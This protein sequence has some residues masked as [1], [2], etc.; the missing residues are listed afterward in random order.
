[1]VKDK[2]DKINRI[3]KIFEG[4]DKP[5]YNFKTD[6][7]INKDFS[8]IK[9]RVI[10]TKGIIRGISIALMDEFGKERGYT[11]RK[12]RENVNEKER[13]KTWF[14][15]GTY[16][17]ILKIGSSNTK[18]VGALQIEIPLQQ[19]P[20]SR[21]LGEDLYD[22]FYKNDFKKVADYLKKFQKENKKEK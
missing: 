14:F 2:I 3:D 11:I 5:G 1:M 19:E 6:K 8:D 12:I 13:D 15:E 18:D 9:F 20:I 17:F 4:I 10:G 21:L 7:Q 22:V 16:R